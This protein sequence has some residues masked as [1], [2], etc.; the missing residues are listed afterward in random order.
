MSDTPKCEKHKV[1]LDD[2]ECYRCHGEGYIEEED[3]FIVRQI[4]IVKCWECRGDGWFRNSRCWQCE[5]EW[6]EEQY[7]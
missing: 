5:E 1:K 7:G 2:E 3:D 4:N 6:S